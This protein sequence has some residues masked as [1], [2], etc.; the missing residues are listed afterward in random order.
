MI[1]IIQIEFGIIKKGKVESQPSEISHSNNCNYIH[2]PLI[3]ISNCFVFHA[4]LFILYFTFFYI[5]LHLCGV[6]LNSFGI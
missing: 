2:N 5:Q 1:T 6:Q 3:K 4:Y